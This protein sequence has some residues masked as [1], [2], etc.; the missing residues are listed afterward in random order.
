MYNEKTSYL[1]FRATFA[2]CFGFVYDLTDGHR[3]TFDC[4]H[5]SLFIWSQSKLVNPVMIASVFAVWFTV[6]NMVN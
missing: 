6:L 1:G 3:I 4:N 2:A 5:K